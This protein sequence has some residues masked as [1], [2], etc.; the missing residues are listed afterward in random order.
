M[1]FRHLFAT[2]ILLFS[3]LHP[4]FAQQQPIVLRHGGSVRTV[5]FSPVNA[6]RLASAG[7]DHTIKIW[8]LRNDTV[9][10]LEGHTNQINSVAFSPNG[11]ILASGSDDWTF[12]LWNI[13]QQQ[14][15][16]TLE[17]ITDRTRSQ[18]K[19]VAFSPNGQTLATAGIHVK[20]WDVSTQ[21]EIATL[22][23]DEYVWG[24]AF[25]PD[26]QLLATGDSV[27]SVKIWNV[28]K[29]QI[30]ARLNAHSNIV[31]SV[32]FSPDGR[33]LASAGNAGT[34]NFWDTSNWELLGTLPN[35][36]TIFT[37][38][39]SSDGKTLAAT[40]YETVNLWDAES[41]GKI[42]SLTGHTDWV[43]GVAFT[44]NGNAIAS[45][46]D[47]GTVRVQNIRAYLEAQHLR[48]IVRLIYFLPLNRL[49]QPDIDAKLDA[50]IKEIQQF[51]ADQMESHGFGRKT[52]QF[53]TDATGKAVVHHVNGRFTDAH[54]QDQSTQI[55]DKVWEEIH[56]RFN[57]SK[58]IYLVAIDVGSEKIGDGDSNVCGLGGVYPAHGGNAIYPASGACFVSESGL[59]FDP[60]AHE[61]GH[62]FGLQ[63]DFRND[64]YVMSYGGRSR[65]QLSA[66]AAEWL[67]AHRYFNANLTYF[68]EPTTFEMLP[69]RAVPPY[70]IRLPFKLTDTDGLHQ[71]QLIIPTTVGDPD[72][73]ISPDG[74]K[75]QDC[76]SL[77]GQTIRIGFVTT[78]LTA[79]PVTEVT[80]QVMDAEGSFTTQTFPIDVTDLLPRPEVISIPDQN[81]AAAIRET[82]G[83]TPEKDITQLD[84][85]NLAG[86]DANEHQ[87]IDLTGLEYA[88]NLR[89]LNL[90]GNQISNISPLAKLIHLTTLSLD[91]N[92]IT[93]LRSLAKL[94]RLATLTLSNNQIADITSLARLTNLSVLEV[95]R[96]QIRNITALV[97]LTKLNEIRILGNPIRDMSPLHALIKAN[98]NMDLDIDIN[99][100][101]EGASKVIVAI[102]DPKLETVVR[103]TLE[104]T[105]DDNITQLDMLNL[106]RLDA[107]QHEITALTGL[108]YAANLTQLYLGQNQIKDITPLT[109]LK[110][111][112]VV[113][114]Y[115]N[116]VSDIK[117]GRRSGKLKGS[118]TS[119]Q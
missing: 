13:R 56:E 20:L 33:T 112:E 55:I 3:L 5:E 107:N 71:A 35:N 7:E 63:H 37:I 51:Y 54:Y 11:Q 32:K 24:L 18:V 113:W 12:K 64:T 98:T 117:P 116:Q 15:I 79:N 26:G 8:S 30:V 92:Q 67:D 118:F 110:N 10:T 22:H 103:Q 99:Q 109:K 29:K 88:T 41:G 91:D 23:H 16:A 85:L 68:N 38:D 31:G 39:F 17:H 90:R 45:G 44:P 94:P 50:Q 82:L 93:E 81:L 40:G 21:N 1:R 49:P 83:L 48:N 100:F 78:Q 106:K 95:D 70:S 43:R 66:C 52:F 57:R 75:L 104:L 28:Q 34:I 60:A 36:G 65:R 72:F 14:H 27:G 9:I 61:L 59:H 119:L 101:P 97:G 102:P 84:M 111:L 80:L 86:L 89:G 105:T 77:N 6:F 25:S 53:E 62:A 114:L 96:N 108:E 2:L 73:F 74:I 4:N 47:D 19:A 76:Q 69:P 58:H 46:G 115:G 87:I 42:V